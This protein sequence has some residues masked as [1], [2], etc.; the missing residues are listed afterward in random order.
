MEEA[1]FGLASLIKWIYIQ[2][3]AASLSLRLRMGRRKGRIFAFKIVKEKK[4]HKRERTKEKQSKIETLLYRQ[5]LLFVV[6][7]LYNN[8]ST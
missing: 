3:H 1:R 5:Q 8:H 7:V 6:C 2:S 4:K